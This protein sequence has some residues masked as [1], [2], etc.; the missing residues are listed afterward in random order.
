M[1]YTVKK[2]WFKD[3]ALVLVDGPAKWVSNGH[4]AVRLTAAP[5]P[6]PILHYWRGTDDERAET[7]MGRA[8]SRT[9][10]GAGVPAIV[11][12]AP[13]AAKWERTAVLVETE[14]RFMRVYRSGER[15]AYVDDIYALPH[16]LYGRDGEHRLVDDPDGPSF[17]V[18][19]CLGNGMAD[20]ETCRAVIETE[21]KH[22][23]RKAV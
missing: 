7:L 22:A 14:E 4:F 21:T 2:S 5:N 10:E 15:V 8:P 18:M 11:G 23:A 20:A 1:L 16:A 9:I 13:D 12:P 6:G 19:P 17:V 3:A